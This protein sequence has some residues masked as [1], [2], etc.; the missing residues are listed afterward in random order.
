VNALMEAQNGAVACLKTSGPQI[1]ITLMMSRI[2]IH[3]KVKSWIRIRIKNWFR[4]R[5][6]LNS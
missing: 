1:R 2:R 5:N 6:M 3:M 4:I